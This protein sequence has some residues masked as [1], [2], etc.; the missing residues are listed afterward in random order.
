MRKDYEPLFLQVLEDSVVRQDDKLY[1]LFLEGYKQYQTDRTQAVLASLNYSIS[2]YL[3]SH[4]YKAPQSV[5]DFAQAS[6]RSFHQER[7]RASAL[8]QLVF[9]LFPNL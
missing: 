6:Q 2:L 9:S 1:Q 7:G 3:L 8:L 5:L 4:Q